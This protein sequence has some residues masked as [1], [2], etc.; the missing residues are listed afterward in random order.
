M[1]WPIFLRNMST[2]SK[3][4]ARDVPTTNSLITSWKVSLS[5]FSSLVVGHTSP[6]HNWHDSD[7]CLAV[8]DWLYWWYKAC[9]IGCTCLRPV[10][11]QNRWE[12]I[13]FLTCWLIFDWKAGN[14]AKKEK[15]IIHILF[16]W[17]LVVFF[18][19]PGHLIRKKHVR[20]LVTFLTPCL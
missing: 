18:F 10:Y 6:E 12:Y 17:W 13:G 19:S 5:L 2:Y 4:L 7:P 1:Q 3:H 20:N 16:F 14:T 8:Q 9:F 15:G 11:W